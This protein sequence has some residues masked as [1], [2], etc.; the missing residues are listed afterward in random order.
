MMPEA[1]PTHI[2]RYHMYWDTLLQHIFTVIKMGKKY[3]ELIFLA[4]KDTV[5]N[6]RNSVSEN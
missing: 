3:E 5:Q 2:V 6:F 1:M 4:K